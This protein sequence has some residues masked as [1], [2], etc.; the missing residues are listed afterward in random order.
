[1]KD[2]LQK[3][4]LFND[5]QKN[6]QMKKVI[7]SGI[8]CFVICTAFLPAVIRSVYRVA[9][10]TPNTITSDYRDAYTGTYFCNRFCNSYKGNS[11]G[12]NYTSDTVSVGI[13]KD[14][15]DSVLQIN[16]GQQILKMKLL[17]KTLQA[18]PK[19]WHFGGKFFDIDSI[20]I[21]FTAG[22]TYSCTYKG[23]KK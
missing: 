21:D 6:K 16:T 14:A 2:Y 8:L 4:L 18:Y 10:N 13:T 9:G 5:K 3:K 12:G 17:N 7:I 20:Y 23:K 22:Q 1:V 11:P 15:T 19:N